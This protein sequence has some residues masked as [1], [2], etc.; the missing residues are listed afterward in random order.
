M[1]V[2]NGGRSD[3]KTTPIA[4]VPWRSSAS[5]IIKRVPPATKSGDLRVL[6]AKPFAR[7]PWLVHGFS[8]RL[9]G[10]SQAFGRKGDLNLGFTPGDARSAVERNRALFL[11]ALAARTAGR[12]WPVV[13]LKQVHSDA[14]HLIERVPSS[15][16]AG[17]GLLTRLPGLLL[18]IQTADCL[19]V[20]LVDPENRAVGAFHAGWR[21]TVARV[22]EKGVGRMRKAFGSDPAKLLAAIGPGARACCYEVGRELRDR[23]ESQFGYAAELFQDGYKSDPVREKYPLLFLTARAPGH[24]EQ[25]G[26][27]LHL[28]LALANRRQLEQA[29]LPPAH[30]ADLGHCTV[31]RPKLLFSYRREKGETGRL[32]GA[33]GI[34]RP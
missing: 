11:D 15:P 27:R 3:E 19:P 12:R 31:C 30:I 6:R 28:D 9:G 14:I 23:F 34:H 32:W 10:A 17:D 21:G 29:G 20:L 24:S 4:G 7:I 13:T 18:A 25:I 22:V 33:I 26:P 5:A 8:T 2:V 1:L 16:L